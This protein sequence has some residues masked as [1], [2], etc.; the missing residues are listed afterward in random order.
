[1]TSSC[2]GRLVHRN[3]LGLVV[4]LAANG[5]P[6]PPWQENLTQIFSNNLP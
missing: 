3:Q 4:V 6:M 2:P 5:P 1:M